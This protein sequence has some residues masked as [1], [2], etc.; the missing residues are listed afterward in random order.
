MLYSFY[1][2][3]RDKRQIHIAEYSDL[4]FLESIMNLFEYSDNIKEF[5]IEDDKNKIVSNKV[6]KRKSKKLSKSKF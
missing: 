1:A 6:M 2:N 5:V 3:M 4:K